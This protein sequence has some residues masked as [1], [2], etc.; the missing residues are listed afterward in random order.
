MHDHIIH[1]HQCHFG[2]DN[3]NPPVVKI[4]PGQTATVDAYMFCSVRGDTRISEIVDMPNWVVSFYFP[5]V[6]FE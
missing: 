6:V 1:K 3:A 5:R 4:A 2:W